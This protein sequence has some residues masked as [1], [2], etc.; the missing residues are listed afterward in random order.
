MGCPAL[1]ISLGD[2]SAGKKACNYWEF[3]PLF[4]LSD[5]GSLPYCDFELISFWECRPKDSLF[6]D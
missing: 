2:H 3:M 6:L 5:F 4:L 1:S